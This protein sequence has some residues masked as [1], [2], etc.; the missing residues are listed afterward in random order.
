MLLSDTTNKNGLVQECEFW[1]NLGDGTISGNTTLLKVFVNRLN[2]SYDKVVPLILDLSDTMRWDDSV[3][4]TKQPIGYFDIASG[5]GDYELLSDEQGNSILNIVAVS[6]LPSATSTEYQQLDR[7]TLDQ[8]AALRAMSP[9]PSDIGVPSAFVERNNT[10]FFDVV[11]NYD[12]TS[13]GKVFFERSPRYFSSSSLSQSPGIPEPFHQL[14]ALYASLDWLL[15]N[16]REATT[17][18]ANLEAQIVTARKDLSD[19]MAKK[20]PTRRRVIGRRVHSI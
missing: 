15:V 9:N 11:P 18:I 17:L 7:L 6:I 3:N 10:I 4:H 13:G 20:H 8:P 14:L 16:K 19:L 2:R 12:A 5:D 1:T